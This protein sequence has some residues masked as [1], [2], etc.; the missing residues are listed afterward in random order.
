[1]KGGKVIE[2]KKYIEPQLEILISF[3]ENFCAVV[4]VLSEHEVTDRLLF[5]TEDELD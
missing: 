4:D 1:M 5:V 2:M 3:S